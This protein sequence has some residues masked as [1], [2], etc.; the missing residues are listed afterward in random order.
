MVSAD[1]FPTCRYGV[2]LCGQPFTQHD[3]GSDDLR[4]AMSTYSTSNWKSMERWE[5]IVEFFASIFPSPF[6]F[7]S[8]TL[9]LSPSHMYTHTTRK[10]PHFR[11][12]LRVLP[13]PKFY[14]KNAGLVSLPS[15][16][17]QPKVTRMPP[18]E[19][20]VDFRMHSSEK[21]KKNGETNTVTSLNLCAFRGS[22]QCVLLSFT[23]ENRA[24]FVW[25]T[26]YVLQKP[27]FLEE[28]IVCYEPHLV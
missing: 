1:G 2:R 14:K 3:R 11:I 13:G 26:L 4:Q 28:E 12:L 18:A 19:T 23:T 6:L 15:F 5:A 25:R 16:R 21:E 22:D 20:D 24:L 17:S 27:V 7:H 9:T 10:W 8:L